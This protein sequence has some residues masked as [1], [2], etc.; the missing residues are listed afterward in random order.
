MQMCTSTNTRT[1]LQIGFFS[2]MFTLIV[3]TYRLFIPIYSVL[4]SKKTQTKIFC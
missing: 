4:E 1:F 3:Y 2:L